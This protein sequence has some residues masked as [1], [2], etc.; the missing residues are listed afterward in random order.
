MLTAAASFKPPPAAESDSTTTTTIKTPRLHLFNHE[1]HTQVLE[2][3]PGTND[4]KTVLLQ[5]NAAELLPGASPLAVGRHLGSWLRS[6]H[7]WASAPAQAAALA[8]VGEN[9]PMRDLKRLV[10]YDAVIPVLENYP[11]L[12][13][14]CREALETVVA[15]L[16]KEFEKVPGAGG[17]E[18]WGM[19]HGD[20]WSGKYGSYS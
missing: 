7:A 13:V 5:P 1:S 18:H 9:R 12:L 11:E 16:G 2:D 17:G 3:L 14:G 20:F 8:A 15:V 4:L 6:Y 19:I 10:T